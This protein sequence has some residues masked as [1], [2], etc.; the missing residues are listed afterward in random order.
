MKNL[1][2]ILLS[3]L[4]LSF[5]LCGCFDDKPVNNN[6]KLTINSTPSGAT[7]IINGLEVGKTPASFEIVPGTHLIKLTKNG[8]MP[9]WE[10]VVCPAKTAK[11]IEMTM[12]PVTA[13]IML[14]SNPS[15]AKIEINGEVIGETPYTITDAKVGEYSAI[16]KK[17]GM[18]PREIRWTVENSRPQSLQTDLSSNLGA[19]KIESTPRGAKIFIDGEAHGTTPFDGKIEQGQH[20]LRIEKNGYDPHERIITVVRE[21][22]TSES[23]VLHIL[24][25]ALSITSTPGGATV[26]LNDRQY[27][28]TPTEIKNL[29]PGNYKLRLEMPGHDP[30]LRDVTINPGYKTEVAMQMD[31]N[32]GGVDIAANPAGVTVYLDGK[33]IGVT[34][35]DPEHKG[36]SKIFSV[37]N[38]AMG[39]HTLTVAHKRA[40]PEKKSVTF[41]INKGQISR[42]ALIELWIPNITIIM[43]NGASY[44]GRL[45]SQTDREV[46]FEPEPHI[47]QKFD[48]LDIRTMT[49]LAIQE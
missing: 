38:L 2:T 41:K 12:S 22:P 9:A 37:R 39:D 3:A 48:K 4:T 21:K 17:P 34:E 8:Y 26:F 49:P 25:G 7:L 24:P 44:T 5:S 28:N 29:T 13:A 42:P 1:I 45:H 20:K 14:S 32:T 15:G 27:E 43:K 46:F 33:L 47:R 6:A 23:I 31:S 40:V 30:A 36:F 18:V 35:P 19:L 16:L 10:T 11:T